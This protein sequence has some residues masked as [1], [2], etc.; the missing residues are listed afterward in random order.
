MMSTPKNTLTAKEHTGLSHHNLRGSV[1]NPCDGAIESN[2]PRDTKASEAELHATNSN[3]RG[4]YAAKGRASR[5]PETPKKK[6]V[7]AC[8]IGKGRLAQLHPSQNP[9]ITHLHPLSRFRLTFRTCL[10][11]CDTYFQP[12]RVDEEEVLG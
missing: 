12:Q 2:E 9:L 10:R 1:S 3:A 11:L 6:T 4:S 7:S 8:P 5:R